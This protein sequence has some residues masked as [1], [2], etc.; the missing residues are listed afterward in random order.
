[1]PGTCLNMLCGLGFFC[2]KT[3][4]SLVHH[5][6][7]AWYDFL[8]YFF[9]SSLRNLFLST[10]G[11][12]FQGWM[13][14]VAACLYSME[15]SI[16]WDF[17]WVTLLWTVLL[18]AAWHEA[19]GV[20][21]VFKEF[22]RHFLHLYLL[23]QEHVYF[24]FL[25]SHKLYTCCSQQQQYSTMLVATELQYKPATKIQNTYAPNH[26]LWCKDINHIL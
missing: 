20:T 5:V 11:G 18:L 21:A 7:D 12:G 9:Y 26:S 3:V 2:L 14:F 15:P 25:C 22:S 10:A 23:I 1:M 6:P 17:S 16:H 24:L 8:F 19:G 4:V 13:D